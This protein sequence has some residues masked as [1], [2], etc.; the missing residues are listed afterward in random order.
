[1]IKIFFYVLTLA[2]L[3]A[4]CTAGLRRDL[5]QSQNQITALQQKSINLNQQLQTVRK[6][7]EKNAK[8]VEDIE[9]EVSIIRKRLLD[10]NEP[11]QQQ[12]HAEI[13]KLIT[14]LKEK[15]KHPV[16]IAPRL[17]PFGK[18]A[19][20]ALTFHL[21]DL[22]LHF[23]TKIEAVLS[24]LEPKHV[25]PIIKNL[26]HDPNLRVSAARILGNLD[27]QSV[28]SLLAECID[29]ENQQFCFVVAEGL[30]KSKDKRG[31]PVM[32]E[33]L[34][35]ENDSLR[36]LAFDSLSKT[37]GLTFD[38]KHYEATEKRKPAIRKWEDWWMQN[39]ESFNF[40]NN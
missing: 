36:A 8:D 28:S 22:D 4:G 19:V 2:I 29:D 5:D 25:I 33:L 1:M 11:V 10:M 30:I 14:E 24:Q 39:G 13:K 20:T 18:A 34:Q 15:G 38:Y 16:E 7:S 21:K 26:L 27:D 32:I 17:R 12:S 23:R 6:N 37:T 40:K 31:I 3:T 9:F 35:N